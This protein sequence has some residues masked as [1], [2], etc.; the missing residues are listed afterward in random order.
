VPAEAVVKELSPAWTE[1]RKNVLQVRGRACRRAKRGG[2][3]QASP[4]DEEKEARETA[5]D[6][7]PRRVDV[8]MRQAIAREVEDGPDE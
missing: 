5:A 4:H 6:L 7:E 3:E 1:K 2:V 8:L